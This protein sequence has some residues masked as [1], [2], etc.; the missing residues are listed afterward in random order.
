[1]PLL[2]IGPPRSTLVYCAPTVLTVLERMK[3]MD[4]WNEVVA[5]TDI[6]LNSGLTFIDNKRRRMGL[7]KEVGL[8]ETHDKELGRGFGLFIF[9]AFFVVIMSIFVY[10]F[11]PETKR[12]PIEEM[13]HIWRTHWYWSRF[14]SDED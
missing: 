7:E 5:P 6:S 14:V 4:N 1:M 10:F 11:L 3:K 12:I 13:N 2:L 8:A 9:F